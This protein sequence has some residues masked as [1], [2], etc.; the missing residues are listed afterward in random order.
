MDIT[1]CILVEFTIY[2]EAG[3]GRVLETDTWW[4]RTSKQHLDYILLIPSPS[5]ETKAHTGGPARSQ[6]GRSASRQ[7]GTQA[8][9]HAGRKHRTN[10]AS[11]KQEA[12][13]PGRQAANP[14]EPAI[15]RTDANRNKNKSSNV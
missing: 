8:D 4:E 11:H 12:R 5:F 3:A 7:A 6:Q 2:D 1:K 10:T 9:G 15:K 14:G 13:E